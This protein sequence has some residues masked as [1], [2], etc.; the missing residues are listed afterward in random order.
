MKAGSL[1]FSIICL[2]PSHLKP[3]QENFTYLSNYQ[4]LKF[5]SNLRK[6]D[7]PNQEP[8]Q[9]VKFLPDNIHPLTD[10][11]HHDIIFCATTKT[12]STSWATLARAIY[13]NRTV[14][15]QIK[16]DKLDDEVVPRY[17][18]IIKKFENKNLDRNLAELDK[19]AGYLFEDRNQSHQNQT[20]PYFRILHTRHPFARLYS[21][22]TD[23]FTM[24]E[25]PKKVSKNKFDH[26]DHGGISA[27]DHDRATFSLYS[28][29]Y[30][31]I[32]QKYPEIQNQTTSK[33]PKTKSN[34]KVSFPNF[35]KFL[36]DGPGM[37][38]YLDKH[39]VPVTQLCHA[40]LIKYNL[41]SKLEFIHTDLSKILKILDFKKVG[42]FPSRNQ[43]QVS[44]NS[45]NSENL[46]PE[47]LEQQNYDTMVQDL[48]KKFSVIPVAHRLKL[49]E[50]YKYDFLL[51]G[52]DFTPF[53]S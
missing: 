20:H 35:V 19:F 36:I 10:P 13:Y 53:A 15:Q 37:N 43:K 31:I 24:W 42:S 50:I 14:V 41:F 38:Q 49:Y 25:R 16:E 4:K 12:G 44:K 26:K 45:K 2:D 11:H 17:W 48:V 7:S 39:W 21:A 3:Y 46:D 5:I 22:Y 51:F 6:T 1:E 32:N 27:H 33:N 28:K 34:I 30:K 52:Y 9:H 29:L 23:K 40:C 47:N 8:W 18:K